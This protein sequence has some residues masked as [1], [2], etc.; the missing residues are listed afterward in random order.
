MIEVRQLEYFLAVY[1][2]GGV[3]R[4]AKALHLAQPSLS[5]AIRALER[6]LKVDL[7]HRVGRGLV[8]SP[9]GEAL[10]EPARNVIRSLA[11]AEAT[12]RGVRELEGGRVSVAVAAGLVPDPVAAWIGRYRTQHPSV[13]VRLE[14]RENGDA[15]AELVRSGDCEI[16]LTSSGG[17]I[18]GLEQEVIS[19]QHLLLV[20]P[21]GTIAG[22]VVDLAD[23]EQLPLV[24]QNRTEDGWSDVDHALR[25]AG[26]Q[27]RIV[28]EVCRASSVIPLILSGA[29]SAFLPLRVSLEAHWRGAVVH[30]TTPS[31][32]RRMRLLVRHDTLSA[33]VQALVELIRFDA[34]RWVTA[35]EQQ[36]SSGL[37]LLPAAL[38]VDHAIRSARVAAGLA[39]GASAPRP[40]W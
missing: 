38:A 27:P 6:R 28:V 15:V 7:F 26:V 40:E 1:E 22:D 29:G 17:V 33:P 32:H 30:E 35:L 14:E 19:E 13:V 21:P 5:Q 12:I 9:A 16:G 4:A 24:V 11:R 37:S 23:L 34:K 10:L 25:Q 3:T 20:S 31:L 8:L 39:A 2:H 18:Q 36:R